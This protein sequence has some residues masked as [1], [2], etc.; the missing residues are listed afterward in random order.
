MS[1]YLCALTLIAFA[2][3]PNPK[4]VRGEAALERHDVFVSGQEG[5]HTYRIPAL[6]VSRRGTVLAF[7]E[8]RKSSAAD[9]GDIDLLLRRSFDGGTTWQPTQ[10]VYE[11]GGDDPITIGNPC[12]VVDRG[13]TIHLVFCRNNARALCTKS[14]DDGATFAAPVEIT[15][16]IQ[17]FD[18]AWT[19]LGSGP[20]HGLQVAAGRI[21]VPVWLNDRIGHTYRSAIISSDDAGASWNA[22]GLVP[23]T[24]RDCSECM[25]V[26]LSDGALLMNMRTKAGQYRAIARSTDGGATWTEAK[27]VEQLVDPICQ[28]SLL[29]FPSDDDHAG[30]LLFS[31]AASGTRDHMTVRLSRDEGR[32]W[33]VAR[34]IH[35][36]PAAYSDLAVAHDK[37]ILCLHENG[38]KRP[39]EKLTLARFPLSWLTAG[40]DTP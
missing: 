17:G 33:P 3:D 14:V 5:Y 23:A 30:L 12:P 32:S 15:K 29:R 38:S 25:V 13:G 39:Y 24:V 16:Q 21:I 35:A 37:T 34:L 7:C 36:G 40:T 18:F 8:G 20:G 2:A 31:N 4:T 26:E 19:R 11:E 22:G 6:V 9:D 1:M 28:A 10:V 27:P